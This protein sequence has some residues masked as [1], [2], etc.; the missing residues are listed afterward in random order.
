MDARGLYFSRCAARLLRRRVRARLAG[1]DRV[2]LEE[3]CHRPSLKQLAAHLS[4][5]AS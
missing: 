3:T 1:E 5:L 2:V 4:L